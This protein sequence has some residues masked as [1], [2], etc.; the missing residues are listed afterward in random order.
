MG[1]ATHFNPKLAFD[2]PKDAFSFSWIFFA[3]LGNASVKTIYTYLGY[4]N[5]CHLGGEIKEPEVNIPRSIFISIA[6]VAIL[7]LLMQISILGVVD[8]RAARYS[9]FIVSTFVETIYGHAAATFATV[10]ILWI[11]FSS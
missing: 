7:Y 8:W 1:G 10:L 6:G 4:Y 3:A 5:V 9:Q 2:F 11:A